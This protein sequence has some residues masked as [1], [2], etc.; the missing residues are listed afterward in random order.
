MPSSVSDI[1]P[2][3][4]RGCI[5]VSPKSTG[6]TATATSSSWY[7]DPYRAAASSPARPRKPAR[8]T[9]WARAYMAYSSC[10]HT[11]PSTN[12]P[13]VKMRPPSMTRN[14][15]TAIAGTAARMRARRSEGAS[16]G[17]LRRRARAC[18]AGVRARRAITR[19]SS[20]AEAT[21][22]AGELGERLLEGLA[23]EFGPQ[24][25]A[26]DELGVGRLPQ[27]VVG[28]PLL[29]AGTDDHVGIVHVG[30]VQT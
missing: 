25:L 6:S 20:P 27:Q 18:P 13:S 22:P 8:R 26:E 29:A 11:Q 9:G 23:R 4:G 7:C 2:T 21:A 30:R 3:L 12:S 1:P 17:S 5:R 16:R 28:Q 10:M 14:R 15:A 19:L 24:L